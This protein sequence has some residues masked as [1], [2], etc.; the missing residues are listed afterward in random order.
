MRN[1]V[2]VITLVLLLAGCQ[3]TLLPVGLPT[4]SVHESPA[5]EGVGARV[6]QTPLREATPCMGRF[7]PHLLDHVTSINGDVVHLYDSNGS[8]LAINDLDNDGDLDIVL[9]NLAQ[10]NAIFWNDGAMGPD[11]FANFSK[12]ELPFG[13]TRGVNI[14]DYNGDGWMDIFFARQQRR[15]TLFRNLGVQPETGRAAFEEVD[16]LNLWVKA[17]TSSWADLDVDGDLDLVVA[18]YDTEFTRGNPGRAGGGGAAVFENLGE[19]QFETMSLHYETQALALLIE[20]MNGDGLQDI[21]V[22]NDF[23]L[24]DQLW[25]QRADGWQE[26][27]PFAT[28]SMNTMS[29][30]AGD[31]NGDGAAEYFS[32]DMLPFEPD[33][34][35]L[36]RWKPVVEH[37]EPIAGDPQVVANV[38]H[39]VGPLGEFENYAPLVGIEATGWSWSSKF[40][41]LDNDGFLDFYVVNGMIAEE[42]FGHL[43]ND[44]LVEENLAFRNNGLGQLDP[45]PEWG[46]GATASG[47]GM[48]MADLDQDGDL[49]IVVNN[50]NSPAQIFENRLCGG[51][52]LLV[53]LAWPNSQNTR[54]IGARLVLHLADGTAI[55]RVVRSDSGYLSGDPAQVHFGVAKGVRLDRLEIVWPDGEMMIVKEVMAGMRVDVTR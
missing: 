22:G 23:L 55:H 17:F 42:L 5:M 51:D 47:R 18:S 4:L 3:P 14:V 53:D 38:L 46:L 50:L 25:L 10:A 9:G 20:D 30:A 7:V 15:P 40:G 35:T 6:T 44:E 21:L 12:E 33:A 48:S 43:P 13:R 32:G 31:L 8:G 26:T 24:G 36:E 54:A 27:Q 34:E 1:V 29:F 52:G 45:A 39:V 28:M 16:G 37:M 11:R 41:D 49:D 19:D 2:L